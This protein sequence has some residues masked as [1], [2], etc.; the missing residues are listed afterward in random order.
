[1]TPAATETE[2]R[3]SRSDQK[4]GPGAAARRHA[5]SNSQAGP[6]ARADGGTSGVNGRNSWRPGGGERP[7]PFLRI[8]ERPLRCPDVAVEGETVAATSHRVTASR[9]GRFSAGAC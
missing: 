7:P 2:L 8:P 6:A 1:M 3:P 4:L 9:P 5:S